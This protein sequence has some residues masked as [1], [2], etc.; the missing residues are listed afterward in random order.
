MKIGKRI[1]FYRCARDM[2]NEEL[3]NK[4]DISVKE[5]LKYQTDTTVPDIYMALKIAKIFDISLDELVGRYDK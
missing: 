1:N 3:A 4:L 5:L 2:T